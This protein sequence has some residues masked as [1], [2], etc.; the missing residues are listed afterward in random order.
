NRSPYTPI[1]LHLVHPSGV[2]RSR[3]RLNG[4]EPAPL[5]PQASLLRETRIRR[6]TFTP[7]HHAAFTAS[8]GLVLLRRSHPFS[9]LRTV[10]L[11]I[12]VNVYRALHESLR[13]RSV[14]QVQLRRS[15][16]SVRPCRPSKLDRAGLFVSRRTRRKE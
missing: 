5:P 3:P 13:T 16:V 9:E 1:D 6:S 12:R 7:P 2:P 4:T 14:W 10:E 8:C 11:H 15:V